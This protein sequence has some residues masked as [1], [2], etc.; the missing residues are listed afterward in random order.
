[1]GGGGSSSGGGGGP[2]AEQLGAKQKTADETSGLQK[3][4]S[5]QRERVG[6]SAKGREA[7]VAGRSFL[8]A[9]G[10]DQDALV[11]KSLLGGGISG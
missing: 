7:E 9:S 3:K 5:F 1:M 2:S 11:K 6:P 4:K 10:V 8:K